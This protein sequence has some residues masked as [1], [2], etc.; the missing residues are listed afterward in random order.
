MFIQFHEKTWDMF[1]PNVSSMQLFI[2]V[3]AYLCIMWMV[4]D[5]HNLSMV[6]IAVF[7]KPHIWNAKWWNIYFILILLKDNYEKGRK[8]FYE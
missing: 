7:W 1:F 3:N 5:H 6:F 2:F 8:A 4:K